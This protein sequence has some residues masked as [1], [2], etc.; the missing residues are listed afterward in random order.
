M[1]GALTT[2]RTICVVTAV[3]CVGEAI[4][5]PLPVQ[6]LN[7]FFESH[8]VECHDETTKK[9]GLDLGSLSRDPTDAESLRRWVRVFDRVQSGEMPPK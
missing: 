9:G 4:A 5:A 6:K 8:C 2:I 1:P 7:P 3:V